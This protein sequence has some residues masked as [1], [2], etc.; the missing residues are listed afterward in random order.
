MVLANPTLYIQWMYGSFGR[1]FIIYTTYM[2]TV[3]ANP[4]HTGKKGD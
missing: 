1:D 3:L 4:T 2:Y